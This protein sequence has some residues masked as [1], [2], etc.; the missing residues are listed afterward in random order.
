[1]LEVNPVTVAPVRGRRKVALP[2]IAPAKSAA[3][4]D[5]VLVRRVVR[6]SQ[7]D[8]TW[9]SR[10]GHAGKGHR[11]LASASWSSR[12]R[13]HRGTGGRRRG[14]RERVGRTSRQGCRSW[15]RS[16]QSPTRSRPVPV[17]PG[18]VLGAVVVKLLAT[19]VDGGDGCASREAATGYHLTHEQAGNRAGG[20][21]RGLARR[22]DRCGHAVVVTVVTGVTTGA[23]D[24]S[25]ARSLGDADGIAGR[26]GN[27]IPGQRR[28]AVGV[29][30]LRQSDR[31]CR[32]CWRRQCC[33]AANEMVRLAAVR[34]AGRRQLAS[35]LPAG[36]MS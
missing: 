2:G 27:S 21:Q 35:R 23:F 17:A 22:I 3:T 15:Y 18:V 24:T 36:A 20:N 33:R 5:I 8:R 11:R 19:G 7:G 26:T 32:C 4:G 1:M 34:P 6:P 25:S 9:S 13:C 30:R 31:R 16:A 12:R 28:G 10:I 29:Q 14:D